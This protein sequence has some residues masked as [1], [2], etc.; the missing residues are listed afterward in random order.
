MSEENKKN[1]YIT[2]SDLEGQ[3]QIILAA[4]DRRLT[5]VKDELKHDINNVQ[6]LIDGYVKA[7]EDFKQ[8]FVIMK[9]EIKQMKKIIKDKLGLEVGAV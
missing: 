4:L 7:Q 5:E 9:E 2:K 6:T 1:E 3:T 8:E